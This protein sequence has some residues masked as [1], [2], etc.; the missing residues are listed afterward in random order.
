MIALISI[1]WVYLG[2][3]MSFGPDVGGVIGTLCLGIF[4][5]TQ[6]NP[7]GVDGLPAG[8]AGQIMKQAIGVAVV[9]GYTVV[10][11]WIILKVIESVIGLR[12]SEE[13]ERLPVLIRLNTRKRHIIN[14]CGRSGGWRSRD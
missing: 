2:Y 7:G 8:N 3:S 12:V 1:E 5:S 10:V 13:A 11:S 6:V 9:G 4:V 14:K